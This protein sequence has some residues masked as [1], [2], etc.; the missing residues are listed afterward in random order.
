MDLKS[1]RVRLAAATATLAVVF[2]AGWYGLQG[3]RPSPSPEPTTPKAAAHLT[4]FEGAVKVKRRGTVEWIVPPH[5]MGLAAG[6]LVLTAPRAAA[7]ITYLDGFVVRVHPDTLLTIEPLSSDSRAP[8]LELRA[9]TIVGDA[10]KGGASSVI[11]TGSARWEGS[12]DA[13]DPPLVDMHALPSTE[14]TIDQRRGRARLVPR[15]GTARGLEPRTRVVVDAQ[16]RPGPSRLLPPAPVLLSPPPATALSYRDIA[17]GVTHLTWSTVPEAASYHLLVDH[18][19]FF[20]QP[21]VDRAGITRTSW[22]LTGVPE[23]RYYWKVAAVGKDG[24][25][26]FSDFSRFTL[27]QAAG[28]PPTLVVDVFETRENVL[29]L[30]GRT[31]PGAT[32]TVNGQRIEVRADGTFGEFIALP[33]AG[34]QTVSIRAVGPGGEATEQTRNTSGS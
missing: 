23:G 18:G 3:P 12:G 6:D 5:A 2:V 4:A 21:V 7:E 16:G 24:A 33:R 28:G 34:G 25:E 1:G 32:L 11:D 14:T 19:G 22:D 30:A 9:G 15:D 8:A 27:V 13:A 10:I 31:D 17:H 26:S 29:H 20:L